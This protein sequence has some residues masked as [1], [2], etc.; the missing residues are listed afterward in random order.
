MRAGTSA[1]RAPSFDLDERCAE[2][3]GETPIVRIVASP[4]SPLSWSVRGPTA[5]TWTGTGA[6]GG[7]SRATP[8]RRTYRPSVVTRSPASSLRSASTY[9]LS[10]VMGD[11]ARTPT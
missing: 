6:A 3:V 11:S 9:S 10:S 5:P 7:Q 4:T 2:L 1:R 8:S